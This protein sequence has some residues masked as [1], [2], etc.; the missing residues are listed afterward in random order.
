MLIQAWQTTGAQ[1]SILGKTQGH[2]NH[3]KPSWGG[4]NTMLIGKPEKYMMEWNIYSCPH[5][6]HL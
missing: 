5:I 6:F 2:Q 4:A 3:I 1:G